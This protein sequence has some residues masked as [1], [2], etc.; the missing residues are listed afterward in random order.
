MFTFSDFEV[1]TRRCPV[2]LPNFLLSSRTR[3]PLL[4]SGWGVRQLQVWARG[5]LSFD[6]RI[7]EF[8]S[9]HVLFF[10]SAGRRAFLDVVQ[11]STRGTFTPGSLGCPKEGFLCVI[12][13]V[14]FLRTLG[15]VLFVYMNGQIGF[16][17]ATKGMMKRG[18]KTK[19]EV[20]LEASLEAGTNDRG[21]FF[22]Q[23][24][25]FFGRLFFRKFG[26]CSALGSRADWAAG[27]V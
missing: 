10:Y 7:G 25:V 26:G 18:V 23:E 20:D 4:V 9:R 21:R 6:S 13:S 11:C 8:E 12:L 15:V 17:I 19:V 16:G 24:R 22:H 14:G 3:C 27:K 5:T 2:M 1:S